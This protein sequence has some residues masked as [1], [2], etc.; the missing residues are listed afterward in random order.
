[1][2]HPSALQASIDQWG[3]CRGRAGTPR[4][5][6][7]PH[8][9]PQRPAGQH[10]TVGPS[11]TQCLMQCWVSGVARTHAGRMQAPSRLLVMGMA[12]AVYC[13][14]VQASAL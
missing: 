7:V 13:N 6:T 10:G 1:M 11:R 8:R 12:T 2:T 14:T 4:T 9:K 5:F 3:P